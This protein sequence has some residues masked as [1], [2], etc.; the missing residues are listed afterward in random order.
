MQ[1][2]AMFN[3]DDSLAHINARQVL[4]VYVILARQNLAVKQESTGVHVTR[5][6]GYGYMYESD[7]GDMG[8]KDIPTHAAAEHM[9]GSSVETLLRQAQ[10]FGYTPQP[11][12][13]RRVPGDWSVHNLVHS[14]ITSA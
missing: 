12:T 4:Q 7:R 10:T 3:L 6:K 8:A 14:Y 11:G 1:I 2:P 13:P 9:V 5:K